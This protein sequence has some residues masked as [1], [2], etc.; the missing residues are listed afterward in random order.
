VV[1]LD[2]IDKAENGVI[3]GLYQVLDKGEWTNKQLTE[4]SASQTSIRTCRNIIFIM[5]VNAADRAIVDYA[6]RHPAV[7]TDGRTQMA[8]H[9]SALTKKIEYSLQGTL[10]F[11][12]AFIGR[13]GAFVPF[14]PM[15][16]QTSDTAEKLECEM[17][18]VANY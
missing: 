17:L 18:T 14:L 1:L 9:A 3:T 5:T 10:P 11:T 7:Y 2:E 15:A 13:V 8:D 4:G 16:A 6:K 12:T